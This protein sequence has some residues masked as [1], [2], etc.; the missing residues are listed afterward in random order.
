MTLSWADPSNS[1]IDKYQV[2]QGTGTTVSWGSW[3]DIGSSSATTTTHT[4]TGLTNGT[5][6]SF[7]IRAVDGST[8]GTA[9]ST[10]TAMPVAATP[11]PAAPTGLSAVP[12]VG[13]ATLYWTNPGNSA[14]DGYE[15]RSG[16]G[17]TVAW[18][19][20]TAI[21]S[22]GAATTTHM[23]TGLT[24]GTQHSFQIRALDGMVRSAASNTATATPK[25]TADA[26]VGF[27]L[28][29]FASGEGDSAAVVVSL[30][31]AVSVEVEV[32]VTATDGS[33]TKGED[34]PAGN[35]DGPDGTMGLYRVTIPAGDTSATLSIATTDDSDF[36]DGEAF[37]LAIV[38]VVST[39]VISSGLL[40]S[41]VTILDNDLP[42]TFSSRSV[43]IAEPDGAGTYTVRL[44][45]EPT[46]NVTVALAPQINGTVTVAPAML[47]FTDG[48]W[49]TPQEVTV[50]AV[51]N[52][53]DDF[54]GIRQVNVVHTVTSTDNRFTLSGSDSWVNVTVTD[55]DPT[56]VTLAGAAG[57]VAEGGT[58]TFTVSIGRSLIDGEILPVPLTFGGTATRG[59]D[60][61]TACP[62]PLP[63]GVT[64]NDLDAAT[65]PTVTFTGPPAL[66]FTE[67]AT[68]V[69]L[70]LSATPDSDTEAG[71]ETVDIG[72]GT[73]DVNS[74]TGLPGGASGTDSLATF[75]ITE[76]ATPTVSLTVSSSGAITEGASALTI[77]ATRS[78]AN[79]SG[80]A[81]EFPLRVKTAGTTAQANDYTALAS[82]ISIAN[83]ASSGTTTFA[84]TDDSDDE[85]PETVIVELHTPPTGTALGSPAEQTITIT[86]NDATTV[87]LAG[88]TGNVVEG[89]TKTFTVTLGRALVADEILPVPLTFG[90]SATRNTDYTTA[91]PNSL[92]D[93]VTC[94]D[95]N[96]AATPTVTFTGPSAEA[97]TLT[98]STLGDSM[99]EV[100]GEGVDI[101]LGTL[102]VNSGT[103]LGGGAAGTD[104]LGTFFITDPATVLT[105]NLSLP[106]ETV[107]NHRR[108]PLSSDRAVSFTT[109]ANDPGYTL[110]R[111]DARFTETAAAL[112]TALTVSVHANNNSNR[113]GMS[114][115]TLTKPAFATSTSTLTAPFGSAAGIELAANTTYW[116]LFD[117]STAVADARLEST[118]SNDEDAG[119][120][121][122]WG[123]GN[124]VISRTPGNGA[125][126]TWIATPRIAVYGDIKSPPP[127]FTFTPGSLTVAEGASGSYTVALATEPTGP[128]TV[129]VATSG[130]SAV[131]VDTDS[132]MAGNQNTLSFSTTDW[133]T[134][135][136][137]AVTVADNNTVGA[138]AEA[139]L[140]HSAS[141]GGYNAAT[142]NVTVTVTDD[143]LAAVSLSVS[144]ATLTEGATAL[145]LTATRSAVNNSGAALTIPLQVKAAD[146][147]AANSD[148]TLGAMSISIAN[149]AMSGTTTLAATEDDVDESRE[150]VTIELGTLPAGNEAGDP[151]E[152]AIALIDNDATSVTLARTGSGDVA[153]GNT[154]TLTVTL[155]R[156]LIANETVTVP[157]TVSGT[158]VTAGDYTLVLS[159]GTDLNN[160]V[161]LN[162]T[163][164]YSAAQPA[165]VF[166]GSDTG[167]QQVAT[168]T[169]TAVSDG[170][171]EGDE[172]LSVGFG[173]VVSNL[174]QAD[175]ST[176]GAGGTMTAGAPVTLTLVAPDTTAPTATLTD[177]PEK[178]NSTTAFTATV[179]FDEA[180]NGFIAGDITVTGG[181]KGAF[182]GSD[183]DTEYTLVITPS[184]NANVVV[185]VTANSATDGSSNT[186][187]AAA[188]DETAVWDNTAPTLAITG[189]P[190]KINDRTPLTATV[191][192]S[193]AVTGF[194]TDDITV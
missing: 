123:I 188:V 40:E 27:T 17:T 145:T 117:M 135:Q 33:A 66:T 21:A 87:T 104:N 146:T 119:G 11:A 115:G 82:L 149:N 151:A 121:A 71:G 30:S 57:D 175:T 10:V 125:W 38:D 111:V 4:V 42:V 141:G 164:P 78:E 161:M 48:T 24:N 95:L 181:T 5:Q 190:E 171:S 185:T 192:F 116:L 85:S 172:M 74:G 76:P 179:T 191:T 170:V 19:S 187:P 176:M 36:E 193:E 54:R 51:N 25:A 173:S 31:A 90:G 160:G 67:S 137:V 177:V 103:A 144:A 157:L 50:T 91:C 80:A 150:T 130:N 32:Y 13:S 126:G 65:T 174:D 180:V 61:T 109:G 72:L 134:A 22:S 60:Y 162:T 77:T 184:G 6:Y 100:G 7:Q 167:T 108:L 122:G 124:G 142:G 44:G 112:N 79:A 114:L 43:T 39:A 102:D 182:T 140:G 52:D 23:V 155:G 3:T 37:N 88:A 1:D 28:S 101:G 98:L 46:A 143:D 148:Y 147:T 53:L 55:E 110:R 189:V 81:L 128:V 118:G 84:V 59:T 99:P 69:T 194:I 75:S 107:G 168:L 26:T 47:T 64:C 20:W 73:L 93:G 9:S 152:V 153:E 139:T 63:R 49:S 89:G 129:T 15:F 16:T 169:L 29:N 41:S 14:I 12:G 35:V 70:T 113:P 163:T 34:Y 127:A 158:G 186:G 2:R 94:N 56:T 97:V 8:N 68:S 136:T 133:D 58:K 159:T 120:A 138:N 45:A 106:A 86:D 165:V 156:D 18:G 178:I 183:G 154:E 96:T 131:T 83:N 105:G 62:T 166:T 132:V 92:P